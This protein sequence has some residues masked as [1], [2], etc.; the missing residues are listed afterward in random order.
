MPS[1]YLIGYIS[2]MGSRINK[3]TTRQ[4]RAR[5]YLTSRR[6]PTRANPHLPGLFPPR[7][8][9]CWRHNHFPPAVA[10][11]PT[12]IHTKYSASPPK[13]REPQLS[14][15]SLFLCVLLRDAFQ[16]TGSRG[17]GA[18]NTD[19]G[20]RECIVCFT[21]HYDPR[22]DIMAENAAGTATPATDRE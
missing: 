8:R 20:A 7:L 11:F 3:D 22:L 13:I 21:V 1:Q 16:V 12:Q 2:I 15:R 18:N 6:I 10:G 4:C 14:L 9:I 17:L 19:Y 5:R